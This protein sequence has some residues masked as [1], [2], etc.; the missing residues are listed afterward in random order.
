VT[1]SN[2]SAVVKKIGTEKT[3]VEAKTEVEKYLEKFKGTPY[4][5]PN[6]K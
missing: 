5:K 4:Y 1:P 6:I 3:T 2:T